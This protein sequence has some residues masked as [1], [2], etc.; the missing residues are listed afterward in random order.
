MR[1]W[2]LSDTNNSLLLEMSRKA[3]GTF[4]HSMS[5]AN[6]AEAACRAIGGDTR[7]VRVGALYHDIGKIDNPLCFVEN[8]AAGDNYH[9]DLTPQQSA[10][11]IIKHVEDG[12]VQAKR[13]NLPG[14]VADMIASHHGTTKAMFFYTKYCNAGGDP[15]DVEPFTYKG[16]L[17]ETKE[18]AILMLA[19]SVEAASRSLRDY[20][21]ESIAAMVETIVDGKISEGQ[22]A[23][24]DITL[25]EIDTIKQIFVEN[26]QQVYHGRVAYPKPIN[27]RR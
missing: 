24:S 23:K 5:V 26:L 15:A 1:L 21:Q 16:K 8:Q 6:L 13:H 22:V 25:G 12:L 9:K 4:Q 27:K 11:D 2:E 18:E 14:Q 19:D 17:P 7:L 10:H 3:P 20:S